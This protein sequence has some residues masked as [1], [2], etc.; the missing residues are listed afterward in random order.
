MR[1]I[2]I[3]IF[4]FIVSI[5]DSLAQ[6]TLFG[7]SPPSSSMYKLETT[8]MGQYIPDANPSR[9]SERIKIRNLIDKDSSSFIVYTK[10]FIDNKHV[11][12]YFELTQNALFMKDTNFSWEI[13][14]DTSDLHHFKVFTYFPGA[15]SRRERFTDQDKYFNYKMF[16]Y[17]NKAVYGKEVPLMIIYEDD[18]NTKKTEQLINRYLNGDSIIDI[19]KKEFPYSDI[20]RYIL[21]YYIMKCLN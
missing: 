16:K 18:L 2:H 4:I 19:E 7:I 1:R 11:P 15:M 20:K 9:N 21:I 6:K 5:C 3:F 8:P 17:S 14:P 12:D 10:E 13:V